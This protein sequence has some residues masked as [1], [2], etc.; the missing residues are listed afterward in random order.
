MAPFRMAGSGDDFCLS[1]AGAVLLTAM[2]TMFENIVDTNTALL[3]A[4]TRDSN[5]NA[6]ELPEA[7]I[8]HIDD[9]K[10]PGQIHFAGNYLRGR[11]RMDEAIV[12]IDM[13]GERFKYELPDEPTDEDIEAMTQMMAEG[14]LEPERTEMLLLVCSQRDESDDVKVFVGIRAYTRGPSNEVVWTDPCIGWH[15]VDV[16]QPGSPP[17][18]ELAV[19]SIVSS[20]PP[21]KVP[22]PKA[23]TKIDVFITPEDAND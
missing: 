19:A 20:V 22:T 11:E 12:M 10:L 7:A 21:E 5:I 13:M 23:L 2:L 3:S 9:E 16:M 17:V 4:T 18:L 8:I 15:S 1:E 14:K 6:S